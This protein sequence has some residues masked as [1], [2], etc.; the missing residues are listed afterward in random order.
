MDKFEYWIRKKHLLDFI[1]MGLHSLIGY[2]IEYIST[3]KIVPSLTM[4]LN[5]DKLD[6]YLDIIIKGF[7]V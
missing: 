6:E 4:P 2:K 3:R 7:D 1:G 5:I